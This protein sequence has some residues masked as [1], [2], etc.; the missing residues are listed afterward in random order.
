MLVRTGLLA[1][2]FYLLAHDDATGKPLLPDRVVGLALAAALLGELGLAGLIAVRDGNVV[3]LEGPWS[4]SG[5]IH[6][7][8]YVLETENPPRPVRDWLEYFGPR[9]IRDVASGLVAS[10]VLIRCPSRLPLRAARLIPADLN[11][12][13]VVSATLVTDLVRF[14]ALDARAAMLAG[15]VRVTRLDRDHPAFFEVREQPAVQRHLDA[16]LAE[17]SPPVLGDLLRQT[18]AAFASAVATHRI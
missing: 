13:A 18:E 5:L 7:V 9:A 4:T 11:S 12:A 1:D 17:L 14:R 2:E 3:V 10:G 8:K 15:L 16:V 6:K